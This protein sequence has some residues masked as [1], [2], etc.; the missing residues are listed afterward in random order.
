MTKPVTEPGNVAHGTSG[1]SF[2]VI[3]DITSRAGPHMVDFGCW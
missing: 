2:G 3:L 1:A